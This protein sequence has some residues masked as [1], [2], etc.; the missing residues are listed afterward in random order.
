MLDN[1]LKW[2]YRSKIYH[3]LKENVM[4][5]LFLG[6]YLLFS[7]ICINLTAEEFYAVSSGS[8]FDPTT[9]GEAVT[10]PGVN[11]DVFILG[12]RVVVMDGASQVMINSLRICSDDS[13]I[14]SLIGPN[15]L[16][17]N[18]YLTRGMIL[19]AQINQCS[20]VPGSAGALNLHIGEDLSITGDCL[21]DVDVTTF[22]AGSPYITDNAANLGVG[23]NPQI[24]TVFTAGNPDV[25]LDIFG[26]INLMPG[27]TYG[28]ENVKI[29]PGNE[30]GFSNCYFI[31]CQFMIYSAAHHNTLSECH[32]YSSTASSTLFVNGAVA[33]MDNNNFFENLTL[34]S[35]GS[36]WG[37]YGVS[38]MANISGDLILLEG[39]SISPGSY[40]ILEIILSGDL[41]I[42]GNYYATYTTFN[43]S[44]T[45]SVPQGLS[46]GSHADIVG[47]FSNATSTLRL[48]TDF[49]FGGTGCIFYIG[50]MYLNDF[51]L[52][53]ATI[54][55]GNVYDSG[56][57]NSCSIS[58]TSFHGIVTWR[59]CLLADSNVHIYADLY[60]DQTLYGAYGTEINLSVTGSVHVMSGAATYPGGYGTLDIHLEGDLTN[61]GSLNNTQ[62]RFV[63]VGQQYLNWQDAS[64]FSG[65]IYINCPNL[66]LHP[67]SGAMLNMDNR[68]W[69][70][71]AATTINL[72]SVVS[73]QNVNLHQAVFEELE[74]WLSYRLYLSNT[75]IDNC[76]FNTPVSIVGY[77]VLSVIG[78]GFYDELILQACLS[79]PASENC[80]I[81]VD[82]LQISD[83]V[84]TAGDYGVLTV[85]VYGDLSVT[86]SSPGAS[87]ISP[88]SLNL[89]GSGSQYLDLGGVELNCNVFVMGSGDI[90]VISDIVFAGGGSLS[91]TDS[92]TAVTHYFLNN[93]TI[94][95]VQLSGGEFDG[96][97]LAN[98]S[99]VN[100]EGSDLE[101][102]GTVQI[103]G[104]DNV[105]SSAILNSGVLTGPSGSPAYLTINGSLH[106]TGT[107]TPGAYGSLDLYCYGDLRNS[108][109]TAAWTATVHLR[110]TESRNLQLNV[111][112]VLLADNTANFALSGSN[113]LSHF[114]ISDGSTVTIPS[115][116]TL[117]MAEMNDWY[118]GNLVMNGAFTNGQ[119]PIQSDLIF[120]D[121]LLVPDDSYPEAQVYIVTHT[122][123]NP[124]NLPNYNGEFWAFSP[125]GSQTGTEGEISLFYQGSTSSRLFA[126]YSY[127]SGAHWTIFPDQEN[128][129][130]E[131]RMDIHNVSL[132]NAMIMAVSTDVTKWRYDAT[133]VPDYIGT[134]RLMPL[135]TWL[136]LAGDCTYHIE[137]YDLDDN[138][139]HISN[140]AADTTYQMI[141]AL[142]PATTYY[143]K[144]A[145]S[146]SIFGDH[147]SYTSAFTT[148]PAISSIL[149]MEAIYLP[150]DPI[151]YYIPAYIQNL[152]PGEEITVNAVP[153]DNLGYYYHEGLLQIYPVEGWTGMETLYLN[154][155]DGFTTINTGINIGVLGNP[156]N[157]Q[158]GISQVD[159]YTLAA[160]SWTNVP[161][162]DYYLIYIANDPYSEFAA[163][164]YSSGTAFNYTITEPDLF[165]KVT[166]CTGVPPIK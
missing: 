161:G 46:R 99:L 113:M 150:G 17:C 114:S 11:D 23:G 166:A 28:F 75:Q 108:V 18:L 88:T 97:I 13:G 144:V 136:S 151:S 51:T 123:G 5:P 76:M 129:M 92:D 148:R 57:L 82:D 21:Y 146:S 87:A 95:S 118:S 38:S 143:W 117:L 112:A 120:H 106:N 85:N 162:A 128:F 34:E 66:V 24:A 94:S 71:S 155:Y 84:L 12:G 2:Q 6:L 59:D 67:Y 27:F 52:S 160:L 154:I 127:D 55:G 79:G 147:Q 122:I 115:G 48:N 36:L 81:N 10:I 152:L 135:F 89:V 61:L 35:G 165:F 109:S 107:I 164:G 58:Y 139:V 131:N 100:V 102:S 121:M 103:N 20:I 96:G 42:D 64:V 149:P 32:L 39:S 134:Q 30:S 45:E 119:P 62:I 90:N 41:D 159:G 53:N 126:Y 31:G 7:L 40:G 116:A 54:Y 145:V 68:S 163:V 125:I 22:T 14:A 33:I 1:R 153:S 132:D 98:V 65:D 158:I 56:I 44:R 105:F 111:D 74:T 69:Y 4:K 130:A 133:L 72:E 156:T 140:P 101:L 124:G 73:I 110:G 60:I 77:S 26:D 142:S 80:T 70:C 104:A 19:M 9:W 137:V 63:G 157:L 43:G 49:R 29:R 8:W 91:L 93:C 86:A 78:A 47:T 3:I 50:S 83:G 141:V 16:T 25:L 138:L 15:D 37:N